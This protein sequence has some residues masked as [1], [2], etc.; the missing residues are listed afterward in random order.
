MR[1]IDGL[2]AQQPIEPI[3]KEF[4][5]SKSI[6]VIIKSDSHFTVVLM[7]KGGIDRNFFHTFDFGSKWFSSNI[8]LLIFFIIFSVSIGSLIC[9]RR[10]SSGHRVNFD[11]LLCS[12]WYSCDECSNLNA[13]SLFS[14]HN[15]DNQRF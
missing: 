14:S 5:R 3:N 8:F 6:E 9:R 15:K 10:S 1:S 11:E 4:R 13:I 2:Q 7:M 12:W